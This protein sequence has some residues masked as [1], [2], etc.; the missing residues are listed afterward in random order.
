M[1]WQMFI[2][3]IVLLLTTHLLTMQLAACGP[4]VTV[5][6]DLCRVPHALL[7]P[8]TRWSWIA[9]W[10]GVVAGLLVG[11]IQVFL[12]GRDY[13][14]A[15]RLLRYKL[16]W[17]IAELAVYAVCMLLYL[18]G[19]NGVLRKTRWRRAWHMFLAVTAATNLLYHFP[20][21]MLLFAR[22]VSS[23]LRLVEAVDAVAYRQLAFGSDVLAGTVHFWIASFVTT[24]IVAAWIVVRHGGKREVHVGIWS[25]RIGLVASLLQV[26]TGIWLLTV[27]PPVERDRLLGNDLVAAGL[28]GVAIVGTLSLTHQ[29]ALLSFGHGG[30]PQIKRTAGTLVLVVATMV[31]VTLRMGM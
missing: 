8:L 13:L 5:A 2:I 25:S 4:L 3:A 1:Y 23:R 9:F 14:P 18:W 19:W 17:G 29:L 20:T 7:A 30:E 21:L 11:A 31:G 16:G 22:I 24:G 6:F 12:L 27:L 26:P 28:L 15:M 10:I